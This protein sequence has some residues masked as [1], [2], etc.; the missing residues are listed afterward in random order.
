MAVSFV[1]TEGLGGTVGGGGGPSL[2]IVS[3]SANPTSIL[4]TFNNNIT[5]AGL[6]SVP[7]NWTITP[8]GGASP[9]YVT[10]LSS[11]PTTITLSITEATIGGSYSLNIPFG[12]VRQSDGSPL[13]PPYAQV[14]AGAGVA[15]TLVQIITTNDARTFDCLFSEAVVESEALDKVNYLIVPTL[16]IDTITKVTENRYQIKTIE[17]FVPSQL[18]TVTASNIHDLYQNLI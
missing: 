2:Q 9:V 11:G 1:I 18:Y 6:A 10:G 12:V 14:F 16:T 13:I 15:P 8:S 4:I 7:T 5:V 17:A 3:I